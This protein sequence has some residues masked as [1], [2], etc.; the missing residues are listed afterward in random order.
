MKRT[1]GCLKSALTGNENKFTAPEN[2]N[3]F[4]TYDLRKTLGPIR[5]QG[6][7]SKCVS[8]SLTDM[9]RYKMNLGIYRDV[10]F[11]D[12]IFYVTRPNVGEEGMYPIDAFDYLV[13]TGI[14]GQKGDMFAFVGNIIDA[15][16]SII[17]NGPLMACLWVKSYNDD[18]WNGMYDIGGHAVLFVGYGK[19]G[20]ILR[21][22]WGEEF[23]DN[24]YVIFP[25]EKFYKCGMEYWTLIA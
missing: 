11:S 21:N 19:D 6:E 17:T 5:D 1:F 22:S 9:V 24:G 16:Y 7:V 10:E 12:D 20:F 15:K 8:V 18:F 25:Y 23:G 2:V 14:D 4:D 3:I 13:N